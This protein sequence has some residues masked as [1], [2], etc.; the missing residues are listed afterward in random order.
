MI[1]EAALQLK[2]AVKFVEL[3]PSA[4]S[5]DFDTSVLTSQLYVPRERLLDDYQFRRYQT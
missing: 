5:S 3:L 1:V 2:I 4:T